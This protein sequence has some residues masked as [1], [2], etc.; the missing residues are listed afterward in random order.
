M[1]KGKKK[2]ETW[3][4][5]VNGIYL[6]NCTPHPIN[7]EKRDGEIIYIGVHPDNLVRSIIQDTMESEDIGG[8]RVRR[9]NN[10]LAERL[11]EPAKDTYYIVSNITL[12]HNLHRTDLL[13]RGADSVFGKKGQVIRW[14]SFVGSNGE[15]KE[16][17]VLHFD[18]TTPQTDYE[19]RISDLENQ[20]DSLSAKSR[21]FDALER[22]LK[23]FQKQI[24]SAR[25]NIHKDEERIRK[26]IRV[27]KNPE[28]R[29]V[30][31]EHTEKIGDILRESGTE[32]FTNPHKV[33]RFD[34][35][36]VW[37]TENNTPDGEKPWIPVEPDE[38]AKKKLSMYQIFMNWLEK[39]RNK[40]P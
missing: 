15:E 8:I 39:F 37:Y 18:P 24:S 38:P 17:V 11:P 36:K 30:E 40:H 1:S 25:Q 26:K 16:V 12:M 10:S 31:Q 4:V 2:K 13:A 33:E 5:K 14:R 34:K 6:V 7:I 32:L 22:K 21:D 20:I 35:Y 3:V 19:T 23:E 29:Q 28:Y 27:L 9:F